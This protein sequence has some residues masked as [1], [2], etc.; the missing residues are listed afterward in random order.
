[1]KKKLY[2]ENLDGLRFM[3]FLFVFFFH[4]FHTEYDSIKSSGIYHFIKRDIC[5][6]GNIGVNFFFVLSGFLI[7][8]LLIEE[9]KMNG[10][11]NVINFWIRRILRIWPLYYFCVFF[12]FV[13]FPVLKSSFGQVPNETASIWYYITF[14]NNFDFIKHG[15]PDASTLGVLWSV[16]I[17]EQFY[18]VWPLILAMLPIK[19]YWIAFSTVILISLVYRG[20]NDSPVIHEQ[21]TLSC[22]GDMAIGAFGAWMINESEWFKSKITGFKKYQIGIIYLLFTFILFFR[23][24]VLF[25]NET[26][27]IFER[28][29]IAVVILFIILEQTYSTNSFFKMGK[30]KTI[31]KLGIITY[32]LYCLHFVGILIATTITK[33]L[34]INTH[35]WQVLIIDTSLALGISIIISKL[36]YNYFE[37]PFL[38]LKD[39]FAYIIK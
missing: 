3:C 25:S 2:F 24:E 11:I 10:K 31:S 27:R 26:I 16:A 17:E 32:G 18:F 22:I 28:S 15:A 12:G 30:F 29:I 33:K 23:D 36:S 7:T 14:L 4:S 19:R 20:L 39:K 5:G 34:G 37:K 6:N 13:I 21:H 8:F 38:K 1:M 35:L 9:K